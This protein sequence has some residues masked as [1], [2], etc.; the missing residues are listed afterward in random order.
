VSGG[1]EQGRRGRSQGC[2][3]AVSKRL[4]VCVGVCTGFQGFKWSGRGRGGLGGTQATE[5]V[6]RV[7][8][9]E[10]EVVI[11]VT[12]VGTLATRSGDRIRDARGTQV[13]TQGEHK[14]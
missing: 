4:M 8:E 6:T 9:V 5:V 12:E 2:G 3:R 1:R 11:R 14:W 13:V 7:T 10:T